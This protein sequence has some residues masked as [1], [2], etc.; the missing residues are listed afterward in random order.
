MLHPMLQTN[1]LP[2]AHLFV[3]LLH[4]C[5]VDGSLFQGKQ[6]HVQIKE[7]A[8]RFDTF[9]GNALI[10]MYAKCGD[11]DT[12]LRVFLSSSNR[13]LVSWNSMIGG[14]AH[15]GFN[16]K[17]L[18]L[19]YDMQ[20]ENIQPSRVTFVSALKACAKIEFRDE[21]R[22]V[23]AQAIEEGFDT[24]VIFGSALTNFYAKCGKISD[25]CCVLEK[26][27]NRHI[28]IW[29]ALVAGCTQ[30]GDGE[31]ALQVFEKMRHDGYMPN[32]VTYVCALK[33]C[34]GLASFDDGRRIHMLIIDNKM[35]KNSFVESSLIDM[36]SASG[37]LDDARKIFDGISSCDAITWSAIVTG[38]AQHGRGEEALLLFE[39]MQAE[40]VE[41]DLFTLVNALKAC[42][43]L[44]ALDVGELIHGLAVENGFETDLCLCSMLIDFYSKCGSLDDAAATFNHLPKH[45]IVTW[46]AMIGAFSLHGN[47]QAALGYFESMKQHGVKPDDIVFVSLLSTCA[48]M[49]LLK[50]GKQLFEAMIKEFGLTPTGEHYNCMVDLLG[51][52]GC[53]GEAELLMEFSPAESSFVGWL[54]LLSHCKAHS[55]VTMGRK[56]FDRVTA[57][58]S[59]HASAYVL[60]SE[61]YEAA[62]MH[63]EA[64]II[65]KMR[66]TGQVWKKPGQASVEINKKSHAFI[67]GDKSHFQIVDIL[68]KL[69]VLNCSIIGTG[70]VPHAASVHS[71]GL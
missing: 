51:R 19:F 2:D 32:E 3:A 66:D 70:H 50:E 11:L 25:A 7:Q 46:S 56:C 71:C 21:G 45:N 14:Y 65:R 4:A 57:L 15:H 42:T 41:S 28:G 37:S 33:A 47:I 6:L 54:T 53:F 24:G 58:D 12:G 38:Y 18:S 39:Q 63:E 68:A 5:A 16:D 26:Q 67:V 49:G 43:C 9:V 20:L 30:N 1:V 23:H 27:P 52:V 60:M 61:I 40:G 69:D 31:K 22:L 17:A 44:V 62:G 34:T 55:R 8:S 35:E 10:D 48:Q 59:G 64:E 13:D 36:Y 29:N